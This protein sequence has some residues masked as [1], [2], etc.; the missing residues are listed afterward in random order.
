MSLAGL[1]RSSTTSTRGIENPA[2]PVTAQGASQL[3]IGST[4]GVSV[5][6]T[7]AIG[8]T[9]YLRAVSLISGTLAALPIRVYRKGTRELVRSSTVL[10]SPSPLQT[11]FEF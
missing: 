7:G 2:S 5:T 6:E 4:A 9:A 11:P 8:L 10:D 3:L 1:F